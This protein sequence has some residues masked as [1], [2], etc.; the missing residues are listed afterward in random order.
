VKPYEN[1]VNY[2]NNKAKSKQDMS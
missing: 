2:M 1:T